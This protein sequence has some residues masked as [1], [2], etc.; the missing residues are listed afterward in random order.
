MHIRTVAPG[1]GA[2]WV[3]TYR[4]DP[5]TEEVIVRGFATELDALHYSTLE[6]TPSQLNLRKRSVSQRH[7]ARE[8]STTSEMHL[9]N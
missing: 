9:R 5:S 2:V 7:S 4:S 6:A 1:M 8:S 3:V